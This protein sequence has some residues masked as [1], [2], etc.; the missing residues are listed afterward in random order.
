MVVANALDFFAT[1]FNTLCGSIP[2]KGGFMA[3]LNVLLKTAVRKL[4]KILSHWVTKAALLGL[5]FWCFPPQPH[6]VSRAA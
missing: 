4:H 1:F 5:G 3:K 2:Q 6:V